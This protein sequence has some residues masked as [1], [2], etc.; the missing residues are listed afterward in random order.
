MIISVIHGRVTGGDQIVMEGCDSSGWADDSGQLK[1]LVVFERGSLAPRG[2]VTPNVGL[3][4]VGRLP[5]RLVKSS[6]PGPARPQLAL[7]DLFDE[8]GPD[9]CTLNQG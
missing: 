2:C 8:L 5:T 9:V 7:C 4:D 6:S 1:R 3:G